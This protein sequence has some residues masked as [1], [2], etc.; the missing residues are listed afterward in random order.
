MANGACEASW[1]TSKRPE[2]GVGAS[3][4]AAIAAAVPSPG[5]GKRGRVWKSG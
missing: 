5:R 4:A 2:S 3:S 1:A